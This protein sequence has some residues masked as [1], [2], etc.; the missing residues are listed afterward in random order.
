M[1][2][3]P[4]DVDIHPERHD[5]THDPEKTGHFDHLHSGNSGS[6]GAAAA[7]FGAATAAGQHHDYQADQVQPGRETAYDYS[8]TATQQP[9]FGQTTGGMLTGAGDRYG[10]QGDSSMSS[11]LE[12]RDA[13]MGHGVAN[14]AQGDVAR[15][16]GRDHTMAHEVTSLNRDDTSAT[17]GDSGATTAG[18]ALGGRAEGN[19]AGLAASAVSG[20]SRDRSREPSSTGRNMSE[21][22][23]AEQQGSTRER[24]REPSNLTGGAAEPPKNINPDDGVQHASLEGQDPSLEKERGGKL[25]GTGQDGSHSAVFGLT[26]DGHKFTDTKHHAGGS[27]HMPRAEEDAND[28]DPEG[29]SNDP[30]SRGTGSE[31]VADQL[32]DPRVAEKGHEGKAEYTESDAK[33][34]AGTF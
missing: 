3:Q 32:Q 18:T 31:R 9:S 7:G 12:G 1:Q 2:K 11:G 19:T 20:A 25:T 22:S 23:P 21:L 33:P 4:A 29:A 26:P 14:V 6:T 28:R 8:T 34:G 17:F 15:D 5:G 13:A 10:P 16:L 30:S 24:S 27:A